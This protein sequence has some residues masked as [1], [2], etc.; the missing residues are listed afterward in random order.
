MSVY[1]H[2]KKWSS[3]ANERRPPKRIMDAIKFLVFYEKKA[4][5]VYKKYQGWGDERGVLPASVDI[6]H[7]LLSG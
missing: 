1:T 3:N 4:L 5:V 7:K 6:S 2:K